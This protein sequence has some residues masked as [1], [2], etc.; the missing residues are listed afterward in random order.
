MELIPI[1]QPR[2][3]DDPE[4]MMRAVD[5]DRFYR[6]LSGGRKP[7][8]DERTG[9]YPVDITEDEDALRIEAE[10]PGFT[11]DEIEV[12]LD[13]GTL[14]LLAER[15]PR[16]STGTRQLSERRFTRVE[17]SFTLPLNVDHGRA[18]AELLDGVLYITLPKLLP[19]APKRIPI[20]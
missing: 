4:G 15:R 1:Y 19:P 14:T 13:E 2:S 3:W 20:T 10:L 8:A 18:E 5:D 11:R 6:R 12:S 17:R 7:P 16:G 9:A